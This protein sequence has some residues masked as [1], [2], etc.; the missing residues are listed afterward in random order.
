MAIITRGE[1][2]KELIY[3]TLS[4]LEIIPS[5]GVIITK[6]D[7]KFLA[8][9]EISKKYE[10]FDFHGYVKKVIDEITSNFDIKNYYLYL[11][12]GIQQI[13][14]EGDEISFN[15]EK[16]KICFFILNSSD[17]T[18]ALSVS[19]G[20]RNK[21][22]TFI[23][24][25]GT[26]YKKHYNGINNY[27]DENINI[28]TNIFKEQLE[29]LKSL[30]GETISYKD[31]QKTV[32]TS[33]N[34]DKLLSSQELVF[35]NL[36]RAY[37]YSLEKNHHIKQKLCDIIYHSK[38]STK[39]LDYDFYLDSYEVFKIYMNFFANKDSYVI[40]NE[41]ERILKMSKYFKRKNIINVLNNI[42]N[43]ER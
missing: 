29:I 11:N 17:K 15:D 23:T 6:Y 21:N 34:S 37:Y 9:K 26:I 18:R 8:E 32:T 35:N 22:Y 14:L 39:E 5:N 24:E 28:N 3:K 27:V 4:K 36:I 10:S 1:F 30:I 16:F 7:G 41:S 33:L 43:D 2:D 20:L 13:K 31:L 42:T 19:L 12:K 25:A 38:F 40:K